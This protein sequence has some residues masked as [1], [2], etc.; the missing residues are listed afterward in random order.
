MHRSAT[1]TIYAVPI[2]LLDMPYLITSQLEVPATIRLD[3]LHAV[4][5]RAMGWHNTHL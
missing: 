1:M 4:F 5:Q 2:K 3:H